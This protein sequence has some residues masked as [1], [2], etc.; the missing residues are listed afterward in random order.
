MICKLETVCAKGKI[1]ICEKSPLCSW[2]SRPGGSH[3]WSD[4]NFSITQ[5]WISWCFPQEGLTYQ[6][7][8]FEAVSL[9]T[10]L[11]YRV[12]SLRVWDLILDHYWMGFYIS[13]LYK[14]DHVLYCSPCFEHVSDGNYLTCRLFCWPNTLDCRN[15]QWFD[16]IRTL[17]TVFHLTN[18]QRAGKKS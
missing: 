1:T 6:V 14:H 5:L 2:N 9:I 11:S 8:L 15:I 4:C 10:D 18:R 3:R 12:R 7:P 17:K 13:C 16:F